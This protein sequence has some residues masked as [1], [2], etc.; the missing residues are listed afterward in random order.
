MKVTG[1][2]F[3]SQMVSFMWRRAIISVSISNNNNNNK[4]LGYCFLRRVKKYHLIF[5]NWLVWI[6]RLINRNTI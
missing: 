3:L 2:D 1:G 4:Y 6:I 5:K